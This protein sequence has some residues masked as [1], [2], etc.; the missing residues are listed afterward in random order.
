MFD[1]NMEVEEVKVAE[2][3]ASMEAPVEKGDKEINDELKS[4]FGTMDIKDLKE[5]M[6]GSE[7]PSKGEYKFTGHAGGKAK[8]DPQTLSKPQDRIFRH[9]RQLY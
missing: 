6:E 5:F 1:P 7:S 8:R 9:N 2:D 4:S 3:N